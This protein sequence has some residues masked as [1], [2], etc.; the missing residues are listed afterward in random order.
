MKHHHPPPP[1]EPGPEPAQRGHGHRPPTEP[2]QPGRERTAPRWAAF[3]G[4]AAAG[5]LMGGGSHRMG[6]RHLVRQ[7]R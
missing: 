3:L 4:F 1:T 2:A 7:P 5:L 6:I